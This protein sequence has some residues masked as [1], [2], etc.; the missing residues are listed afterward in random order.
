MGNNLQA[1]LT[2]VEMDEHDKALK[3]IGHVS[4]EIR[5]LKALNAAR[6][7]IVQLNRMSTA[8]RSPVMLP[9]GGSVV[10]P[11]GTRVLSHQDVN[12]DVDP[13]EVRVVDESSVRVGHGTH[14]PKTK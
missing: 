14:N 4:G 12:V 1:I 13:D 11:H 7:T 9:K 3:I 2:Y 5:R 8:M 10:V 6:E